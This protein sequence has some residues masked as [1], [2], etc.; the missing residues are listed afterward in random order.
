MLNLSKLAAAEFHAEPFEYLLVDDF[1][2]PDCKSAIVDDF[3]PIEKSGSFP[4]SRVSYGPAFKQL[5]DALL[6]PDF[7]QGVGAKFSMDL[8][9]YPT[10]LTVRGQ[11]DGSDGQIHT[12]SKDKVITVLLYLNPDWESSGGRL[13]LLRSKDLEDYIAEV[14]PTIGSLIIFKRSDRSWHAHKPFDGKRLSLQMN[15]VKSDRYLRKERFR[16]EVSSFVK[17]LV[18]RKSDE[19]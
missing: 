6:G 15:W 1:L 2:Q 12:D 8:S 13:R 5:T 18:G 14:P 11:C 4:L 9:P 17:G 3:P 10:M 19:G 16:H 7:A